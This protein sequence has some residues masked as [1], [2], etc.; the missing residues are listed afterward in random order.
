MFLINDDDDNDD[1]YMLNHHLVNILCNFSIHKHY[2]II[3]KKNL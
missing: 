3:K 1:D 2:H